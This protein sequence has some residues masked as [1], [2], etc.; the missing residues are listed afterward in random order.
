MQKIIVRDC[1][2]RSQGGMIS[3][4]KCLDFLAVKTTLHFINCSFHWDCKS[5]VEAA[6]NNVTFENCY[7]PWRA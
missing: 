6:G 1:Y 5:I 4:L 7:F 2:F 3:S